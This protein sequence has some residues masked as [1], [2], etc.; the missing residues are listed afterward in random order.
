MLTCRYT[1]FSIENREVKFG[2]SND[3]VK[4]IVDPI[5]DRIG[6]QE[7]I[8]RVSSQDSNNKVSQAAKAGEPHRINI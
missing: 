2:V 5:R 7:A 6:A 3:T 8:K 1:S 4:D